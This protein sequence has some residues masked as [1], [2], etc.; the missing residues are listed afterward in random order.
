MFQPLSGRSPIACACG[1]LARAA[2]RVAEDGLLTDFVWRSIG[3]GSAGGRIVDVESLD[4]DPRF[5]LVA[6][7]SG[8]RLEERERRHHVHADLRPLRDR[9]DRRRRREPEGPAHHLGRH[10]RS[11]QPQRRRVGRRRLQ[12][13][14]RRRHLHERRAEGHLPDRADRA[15]SDRCAHRLRRGGRRPVGRHGRPRAV[16]DDRRRH[17][18]AEAAAGTAVGQ[19]GRRHRPRDGSRRTRRPLCR[20]LPAP[21]PPVPVRLRRSRQRAV[22]VDRRRQDVAAPDARAARR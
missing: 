8:R 20:L 11:E 5:V 15:P 10:R 14:R 2:P 3:P 13:D 9:V 4:A 17:D 16:Q 6:S 18:V 21:A 1:A 7:A 19:P 12:V 22:Q